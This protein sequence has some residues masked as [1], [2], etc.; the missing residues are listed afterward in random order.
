MLVC[1]AR[2]L[3]TSVCVLRFSFSS[4]GAT[5]PNIVHSMLVPNPAQVS[6]AWQPVLVVTGLGVLS[7]SIAA[8]VEM[9]EEE[10]RG[11]ER[12]GEAR[13]EKCRESVEGL[14]VKSRNTC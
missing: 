1:G 14:L 10:R 4:N 12:R 5:A 13:M 9:M 6:N 7:T 8:Y 3:L 11:E 2:I